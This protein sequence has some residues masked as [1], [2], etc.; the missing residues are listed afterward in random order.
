MTQ[1]EK[2]L[3]LISNY[4][5]GNYTTK[6]FCDQFVEIYCE[7][8][9]ENVNADE[10]NTFDQICKLAERFSPYDEDLKLSEFFVDEGTFVELYKQIDIK[11]LSL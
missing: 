10:K 7:G 2:L 1:K 4:N 11:C 6:T 8:I 5:N 3:Y 9:G